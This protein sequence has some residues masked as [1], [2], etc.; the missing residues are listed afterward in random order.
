MFKKKLLWII[1]FIVVVAIIAGVSAS[2]KKHQTYKIIMPEA[3][4]I[5]NEVMA[6]AMIVPKTGALINVGSRLSGTVEKLN[7]SIGDYV[8][9]GDLIAVI[10]HNDIEQ[11]IAQTKSSIMAKISSLKQLIY[12]RDTNITDLKSK[13][14]E[15]ENTLQY[16]RTNFYSNRIL[17]KKGFISKDFYDNLRIGLENAEEN[18]KSLKKQLK[19]QIMYY[20]SAIKSTKYEISSLRHS[21]KQEKIQLSYAFIKAPIAGYIASISTQKGETVASSFSTPTFVTIINLK[22]LELQVMVDDS[23]IA[24][25]NVGDKVY[26]YLD[27]YPNKK[28]HAVVD[29]IYPNGFLLNQVTYYYVNCRLLSMPPSIKPQ[30]NANAYIITATHNDVL[31]LPAYAVK[32][33]GSKSFVYERRNGKIIK[34]TVKVGFEENGRMEILSGINKKTKIVIYNNS[35]K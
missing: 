10:Q 12:Q 11:Q 35:Y 7:V 4:S 28:L 27:A 5:S 6:S 29:K 15:A 31:T 20:K 2:R 24:S 32:F 33:S 8:K 18:S 14:I 22:K 19:N 25:I 1:L 16:K 3:G 13:L 30:M 26:F 23:D 17:F 9:K 21:L 34:K